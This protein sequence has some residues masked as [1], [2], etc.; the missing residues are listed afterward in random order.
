MPVKIANHGIGLV[1][2]IMYLFGGDHRS[3]FAFDTIK[4]VSKCSRG[5]LLFQDSGKTIRRILLA[6]CNV[7]QIA[8]MNLIFTGT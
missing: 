7:F 5:Q 1:D 2:N 8:V 6:V 3:T 4:K